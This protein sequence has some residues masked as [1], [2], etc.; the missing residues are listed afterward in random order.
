MRNDPR[1]CEDRNS[2]ADT[3]PAGCHSRGLRRI[4]RG[5]S[6]GVGRG[7]SASPAPFSTVFERTER[8]ESFVYVPRASHLIRSAID[9][10][11]ID[12]QRAHRN[13]ARQPDR[14]PRPETRSGPTPPPEPRPQYVSGGIEYISYCGGP[15]HGADLGRFVVPMEARNADF[16]ASAA[17]VG[18]VLNPPQWPKEP[19]PRNHLL[20]RDTFTTADSATLGARPSRVIASIIATMQLLSGC[21]CYFLARRVLSCPD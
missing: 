18:D 6:Q 15:P 17:A 5:A 19:V 20:Q 10:E 3:F 13:V 4:A 8:R 12:R 2:V 14:P 1:G 11:N 9:V 21:F 16:T 7:F